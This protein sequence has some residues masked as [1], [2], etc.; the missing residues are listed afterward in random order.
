MA[1]KTYSKKN[2]D[3]LKVFLEKQTNNGSKDAV[4]TN[5]KD[6]EKKRSI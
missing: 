6:A 1:N 4:K 2:Q 3:K 5:V